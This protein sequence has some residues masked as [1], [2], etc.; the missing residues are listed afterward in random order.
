M[1]S[2]IFTII[3]YLIIV[4]FS[5]FIVVSTYI[6]SFLPILNKPDV[7]FKIQ[8]FWGIFC[9]KV[10]GIKIEI[11][12][13]ENI[14][15]KQRYLVIANHQSSFDIMLLF[16]LLNINFRFIIKEEYFKIPILGRTFTAAEH[17]SINR[18]NSLKALESLNSALKL[19][20]EKNYSIAIFPEGT[21]SLDGKIHKFKAGLTFFLE[22]IK[23]PILPI[24]IKGTFDIMPKKSR[25]INRSKIK[26][27]I[28]KSI[29][30]ENFTK[31]EKK[32]LVNDLQNLIEKEFENL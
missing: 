12:G 5:F 14:N 16:K 18:T 26:V 15:N 11:S 29:E 24:V 10:L 27:K 8:R 13:I 23:I 22:N 1:Y 31:S 3:F 2:I 17:I 30:I 19:I 32:Q 25:I 28:L 21:R 6:L 4:P 7:I 20:T 9:L